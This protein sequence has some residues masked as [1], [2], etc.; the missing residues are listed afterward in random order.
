[1]MKLSSNLSI[2]IRYCTVYACAGV[3]DL[4]KGIVHFFLFSGIGLRQ[5]REEKK[6]DTFANGAV[7]QTNLPSS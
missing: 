5:S 4:L 2:G 6:Q 7:L 1:M 3:R